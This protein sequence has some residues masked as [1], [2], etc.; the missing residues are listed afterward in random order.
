MTAKPARAVRSIDV[1]RESSG[2]DKNSFG[3]DSDSDRSSVYMA[4]DA[5]RAQ[6]PDRRNVYGAAAADRAQDPEDPLIRSEQVDHGRHYDRG[7]SQIVC[8]HC[9]L[10]IHDDRGC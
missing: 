10:K 7:K 3:S 1:E 4:T 9:G 6:K 8:T 5:D 2:S